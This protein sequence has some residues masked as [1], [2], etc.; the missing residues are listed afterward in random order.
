MQAYILISGFP[1]ADVEIYWNTKDLLSIKPLKS[2]GA[3]VGSRVEYQVSSS[4]IMQ[5]VA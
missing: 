3:G 4:I 2:S 5:V 1:V